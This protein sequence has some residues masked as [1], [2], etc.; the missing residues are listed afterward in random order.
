[1]FN[2]EQYRILNIAKRLTSS[3][4]YP[5]WPRFNGIGGKEHE[6]IEFESYWSSYFKPAVSK[7]LAEIVQNTQHYTDVRWYVLR[8]AS[9]KDKNGNPIPK[10][11]EFAI[12]EPD[13]NDYVIAERKYIVDRDSINLRDF[14]S[15]VWTPSNRDL[16]SDVFLWFTVAEPE[17][18]GSNKEDI[19]IML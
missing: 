13:F 17:T 16:C 10:V 3:K 14:T 4:S 1:M 19:K 2:S 6:S 11:G 8:A 7:K 12:A 5:G 9:A 18:F 15:I